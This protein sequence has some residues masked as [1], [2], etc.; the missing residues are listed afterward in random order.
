MK[1]TRVQLREMLWMLLHH[2]TFFLLFSDKCS[3]RYSGKSRLLRTGGGAREFA[4][5]AMAK[6]Y[7]RTGPEALQYTIYQG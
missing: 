3:T 6:H 5:S 7:T 1:V 2:C 4:T